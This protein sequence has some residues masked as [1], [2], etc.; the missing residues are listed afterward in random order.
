MGLE[1]E[2]E[3]GPAGTVEVGVGGGA[4]VEV[5]VD[6]ALMGALTAL[7]AAGDC[8]ADSAGDSG[9]LGELVLEEDAAWIFRGGR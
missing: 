8:S 6:D 2:V 7:T 3:V 9:F 1:L 4:E 5:G